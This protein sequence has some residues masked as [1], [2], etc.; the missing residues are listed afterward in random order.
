[1]QGSEVTTKLSHQI[2]TNATNINQSLEENR[3]L[4]K[5]N[6]LLRERIIKIEIAQMRN[7][8]MLSGMPE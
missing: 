4:K 2:E 8:I 7:N 6:D 5:E 1:M 3:L